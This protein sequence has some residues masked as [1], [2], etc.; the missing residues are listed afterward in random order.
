[1]RNKH[2][3]VGHCKPLGTFEGKRGLEPPKMGLMLV[4]SAPNHPNHMFDTITSY[5]N[6]V[7]GKR[8]SYRDSWRTQISQKTATLP[9]LDQPKLAVDCT[10]ISLKR[11]NI[12]PLP[13]RPAWRLCS[14]YRFYALLLVTWRFRRAKSH[15]SA[16]SED[17]Y[18]GSATGRYRP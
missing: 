18:V 10:I 6:V 9:Y 12:S 1:M 8:V 7:S 15:K 3:F 11:T 4:R 5:R 16:N 13:F 2:A 17:L 14:A